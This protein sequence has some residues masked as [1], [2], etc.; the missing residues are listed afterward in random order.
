MVK[1]SASRTQQK[2]SVAATSSDTSPAWIRISVGVAVVA[3]ACACYW[4]S[5]SRET[6]E[7]ANGI[8]EALQK[9]FL[10]MA[11]CA[12]MPDDDSAKV[13][14]MQVEAGCWR[15]GGET[16]ETI[17]DAKPAGICLTAC[18]LGSTNMATWLPGTF[19]ATSSAIAAGHIEGMHAA[20]AEHLRCAARCN[21]EGATVDQSDPNAAQKALEV[22]ERCG[23]VEF[24][25]LFDAELLETVRKSISTLRSQEG[26]YSALLDTN[27]HSGRYQ[28]FLPFVKPFQSRD[29]L[30]VSDLVRQVLT[31]YFAKGP[32]AES[33]WGIDHI[34]VISSRKGSKN[35]TLHPDVPYRSRLHLSVHTALDDI[36]RDMGPTYFC[37]CSGVSS[38]HEWGAQAAI[39]HT[40]LQ[41]QTCLS[42]PFFRDFTPK[43]A[44]KIYDGINFHMGLDNWSEGDRHVLKLE[45]GA[46][47]YPI[48]RNFTKNR[49]PEVLKNVAMFRE[50]FGLPTFGAKV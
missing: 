41:Q 31:E 13:I 28:V 17:C 43:G 32:N 2:S 49:Q 29:A 35:Q 38:E 26:R 40:I 47:D 23:I 45:T 7:G 16:D 34:S 4:K 25:G 5:G 37:P 15:E 33:G 44:Q 24:V 6:G 46:G 1:K 18:S 50:K 8:P 14:A 20:Y 36:T 27:L 42:A 30:G 12:S 10:C 11:R 48:R 21:S 3:G 22:L 19:G 9:N 39:R